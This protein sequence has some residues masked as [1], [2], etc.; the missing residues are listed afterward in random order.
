MSLPRCGSRW[1]YVSSVNATDSWPR[2]LL[3]SS[4]HSPSSRRPDHRRSVPEIIKANALDGGGDDAMWEAPCNRPRIM[5]P[6]VLL[7]ED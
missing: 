1:P 2:R 4:G 7:A 5:R 3:T 6:A